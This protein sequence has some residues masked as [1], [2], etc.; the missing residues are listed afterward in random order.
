METKW[1]RRLVGWCDSCG[2]PRIE[3]SD[4]Y[5]SQPSPV[6]RETD[7]LASTGAKGSSDTWATE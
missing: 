4:A 7:D 2:Q 1:G 6:A 5:E 3:W